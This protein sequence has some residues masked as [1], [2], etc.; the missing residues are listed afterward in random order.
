MLAGGLLPGPDGNRVHSEQGAQPP[1]AQPAPI[2]RGAIAPGHSVTCAL[3][4]DQQH[5]YELT[6]TAGGAVDVSVEQ[7]GIDVIV[8]VSGPDGRSID[9]VDDLAEQETPERLH[10]VA[11]A[12]GPYRLIVRSEPLPG[13]QSGRYRID[14]G[15][16]RVVTAEDRNRVRERR[17]HA[18]QL[19]TASA[20]L[21]EIAKGRTP[22][23]GEIQQLESELDAVIVFSESRR[24]IRQL[25]SAW[26][27]KSL[28]LLYGDRHHEAVEINERRLAWLVG[29]R[30]QGERAH[31]LNHLADALTR[32]GETRRAY[33]AYQAA[34]ALPLS[35]QLAAITHDN[36]G[37]IFRR[38]GR[39]QESLDAHHKALAYFRQAGPRRSEAVVLARLAS[40]WNDIGDFT[41]ALAVQQEALD[42][43]D[44]IG[45]RISVVRSLNLRAS[46][47]LENL[48]DV[49]AARIAIERARAIGDI[50]A[51]PI[52]TADTNAVLAQIHLALADQPRAIE[53]GGLA[54]QQVQVSQLP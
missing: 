15:P 37:F 25:A 6:L 35:P 26:R 33:D 1:A 5:A 23:P 4:P 54:L 10:L 36:L 40:V 52:N 47:L 38:M 41:R 11:E 3:A 21:M 16:V 19:A 48:D 20:R 46:W 43:Y 27:F 39:L 14:V 12:A 28:L 45:D 53:L 17:R 9:E 7:Q 18:E 8:S 2:E 22:G 51:A 13:V 49:E 44:A 32:I 50:D 34:L 30:W 24:Y 29:A 31:A 42:I